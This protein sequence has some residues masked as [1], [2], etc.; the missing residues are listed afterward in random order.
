MIADN[1]SCGQQ[2]P[3]WI[4]DGVEA[5]LLGHLFVRLSVEL[6]GAT[7]RANIIKHVSGIDVA[8][9]TVKYLIGN[10]QCKST[11]H[12]QMWFLVVGNQVIKLQQPTEAFLASDEATGVK[13][14]ESAFELSTAIGRTE[15]VRERL[16]QQW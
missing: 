3:H 1:Q 12:D 7:A 6:S 8:T 11:F 4:R 14:V 9:G 13:A 10:S 16:Q 5:L 15:I 2:S